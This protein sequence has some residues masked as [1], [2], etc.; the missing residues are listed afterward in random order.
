MYVFIKGGSNA[1][2]QCM[3]SYIVTSLKNRLTETVLMR[4]TMYV[5]IKGVLIRTIH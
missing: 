4:V 3:F 2:S 1:G 5:F